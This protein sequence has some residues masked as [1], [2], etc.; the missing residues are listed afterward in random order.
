MFKLIQNIKISHVIKNYTVL[1]KWQGQ[2][3]PYRYIGFTILVGIIIYV[4]NQFYRTQHPEITDYIHLKDT[5][6]ICTGCLLV[7]TLFYSIMT[8][9]YN[10]LKF[11]HDNKKAKDLLTYNTATEWH[12]TGMVDIQKKCV[13]L[14]TTK[15]AV[16]KN[17]VAFYLFLESSSNIDD[18]AAFASLFNYFES[19]SIG[20]KQDLIDKKFIKEFFEH[21]FCTNHD[22]YISHIEYR[23]EVKK[24]RS[25]WINYT[26]LVEEWRK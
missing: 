5:I 16:F 18:K 21:I 15:P 3:V 17:K 22:L 24:D 23:R 9:E 8:Y 7:V 25:I 4:T 20:V 2:K 12:K 26:N 13:V 6:Q 14:R 1:Q 11:K 10:H 19:I